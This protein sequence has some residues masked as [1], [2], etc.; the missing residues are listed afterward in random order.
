MNTIIDTDATGPFA[1]GT[2]HSEQGSVDIRN[3]NPNWI[4]DG[5]GVRGPQ[6][7]SGVEERARPLD[8]PLAFDNSRNA[9]PT[10]PSSACAPTPRDPSETGTWV[11]GSVDGVCQWIG[12]ADCPP[13]P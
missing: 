5:Y 6:K 1:V 2:G 11:W 3:I 7:Q 13:P 8:I 12:T 9:P 4:A 10:I